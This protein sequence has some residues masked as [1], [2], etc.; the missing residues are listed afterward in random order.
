M[1]TIILLVNALICYVTLTGAYRMQ[2][3]FKNG[4][5]FAVSLPSAAKE[6]A[7]VK[8][9]QH[10]FNKRYRACSIWMA[11]AFA[12]TLLLMPWTAYQVVYFLL[13][14]GVFIA[15]MV[16]PFRQ[17]FRETLALKRRR[18][19]FVGARRAIQ[20]DLRAARLK[21]GRS[22][23]MW[24]FAIP[25]L[26]GS[27]A[28]I[29]AALTNAQLIALASAGLAM[30]F[31]MFAVSVQMR[32][33]KA[34]VYSMNSDTNVLLN[35]ARRRTLSYLWLNL[36]VVESAHVWIIYLLIAANRIGDWW[37]ALM[38]LIAA[39]PLALTYSA[40]RKL[41]RLEHDMLAD[42]GSI[43]Y[44]D[45]DEYWGNGFTY[46]NPDDRRVFVEKRIGIGFTVNTG[47]HV[48]KVLAWGTVGLTAAVILVVSF[49]LI[50]SELTSPAMTITADDRVEI[51]YPMYSYDFK[52]SDV[53]RIELVDDVPSG[54]K[55]NG[56]VT[57]RY[58]RGH[59]RLDGLG[60]A[61]LYVF[62]DNPPYIRMKLD[63]VYI[64][65]NEEDPVRTKARFDE[66]KGGREGG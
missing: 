18:D 42:D 43:V 62:N 13:W 10:A 30:T 66:L 40:Y 33:S 57:G 21:N 55:T 56:E 32:R 63:G 4:M 51:A 54:V 53:E 65:Y 3:G 23:P 64:Y 49:M 61:R 37:S 15:A 59:F 41:R 45:D 48:G 25:F 29:H 12:P 8:A 17:A 35:Q 28:I 58:S 1:L 16:M 38:L 39:I 24:L 9:I 11:A 7:E 36:A 60:K 31:V 46:H 52:L 44:T 22:A 34:K 47:T 5:L 50:R 20:S 2:A 26:I 14:I 6:D 27:G 19:W